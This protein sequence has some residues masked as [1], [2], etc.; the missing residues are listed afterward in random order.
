MLRRL[1]LALIP[2][3]F[4]APQAL[5]NCVG[6][7][8]LS[9][10]R[11]EDPSG[12][13]AMFARAHAI[14]NPQGLFWKVEKPGGPS[15][16]L[17][18]T[19][20]IS[21]VVDD[22]PDT[23]WQALDNARIAIFELS[24]EEQ[25]AMNARIATDPSFTMDFSAPPLLSSLTDGQRKTLEKALGTRGIPLEAAN[26]MQP[27][28]L[29]SLLGFPACHLR[30]AA[31]GAQALDNVMAQRARDKGIQT[32]GLETYEDA[33]ASFS[34]LSRDLLI[35][36]LVADDSLLTREEDIFRTN[37]ALYLAGETAAINEISIWLAERL[38]L[39]FDPRAIN[40]RLMEDL[41]DR[42]NSN[43]MGKLTRQA[44]QGGAFIAVGAL[45]L[46]GETGLIELLRAEGF[47]VT[48]LD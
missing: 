27:W 1:M 14:P 36:V 9:E 3:L 25:D 43:W 35:K 29:A 26:N 46:P 44:N 8:M 34:G 23:V 37:T 11:T 16:Y 32:E 33:L 2:A 5:A 45:H 17:F 12:V 21:E 41:L 13:D 18:G 19:F 38:D 7:D 6:Q 22:V 24:Q 20:H 15:S 48:R 4:L 30:A 10:L 31:A 40:E 42:R 28:L 39:P 47:K